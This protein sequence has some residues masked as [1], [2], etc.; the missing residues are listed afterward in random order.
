MCCGDPGLPGV[1]KEYLFFSSYISSIAVSRFIF[2]TFYKHIEYVVTDVL[3]LVCILNSI[4]ASERNCVHPFL[5]LT[6]FLA[7]FSPATYLQTRRD[8]VFKS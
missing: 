6:F 4:L 7:P 1:S 5:L 8:C 3:C 2:F